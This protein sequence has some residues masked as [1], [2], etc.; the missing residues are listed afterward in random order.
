MTVESPASVSGVSGA[1]DTMTLFTKP[2]PC[3]PM[4]PPHR[5]TRYVDQDMGRSTA[6]DR[7]GSPGRVGTSPLSPNPHERALH[8]LP[9]SRW[10]CPRA[11]E[12]PLRF[13]IGEVRTSLPNPSPAPM[14]K[15]QPQSRSKD[16]HPKV[17]PTGYPVLL[18]LL[19][20]VV[21]VALPGCDLAEGILKIG[22]WG[23]VIVVVLI[24]GVVWFVARSVRKPR[25]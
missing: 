4:R 15:S 13:G 19:A 20:V 17:L 2:P 7:A 18:A 25:P 11:G 14:S 8:T 24:V 22:F 23:G 3:A 16:T 6:G 12:P 9:N 10:T 21:T 5:P 1:E